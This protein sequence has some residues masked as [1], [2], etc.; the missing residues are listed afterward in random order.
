MCARVVYCNSLMFYELFFFLIVRVH[1]IK[2]DKTSNQKQRKYH[3]KL[4]SNVLTWS[5]PACNVLVGENSEITAAKSTVPDTNKSTSNRSK[6]SIPSTSSASSLVPSVGNSQTTNGNGGIVSATGSTNS[7]GGNQNKFSNRLNRFKRS[8]VNNAHEIL[9]SD[10]GSFINNNKIVK[11]LNNTSNQNSKRNSKIANESRWKRSINSTSE[12]NDSN[13]LV[14][15][16]EGSGFNINVDESNRHNNNFMETILNN[17]NTDHL[18]ANE[19]KHFAN[20]FDVTYA[21]NENARENN[22]N[23][24]NIDNQVL[25]VIEDLNNENFVLIIDSFDNISDSTDMVDVFSQQDDMDDER[26]TS[27]SNRNFFDENSNEKITPSIITTEGTTTTTSTISSH[28]DNEQPQSGEQIQNEQI[29]LGTERSAVTTNGDSE[30]SERR[31]E[32]LRSEDTIDST[33]QNDSPAI[34]SQYE[35]QLPTKFIMYGNDNSIEDDKQPQYSENNIDGYGSIETSTAIKQQEPRY[36]IGEAHNHSIKTNDLRNTQRILVNVSIATDSGDGTRNHGIYMLHVSVPAP[37]LMPQYYASN[38]PQYFIQTPSMLID[39][40]MASSQS[41][42]T[43]IE[44][45]PQTLELSG[46]KSHIEASSTSLFSPHNASIEKSIFP[47]DCNGEILRLN[48][49]IEQLNKT[50][51][52]RKSKFCQNNNSYYENDEN[53]ESSVVTE[54][55]EN[56]LIT[57]DYQTSTTMSS[58]LN[59]S[60]NSNNNDSSENDF[61]R[62]NVGL[63]NQDIPPILI[64]E[65]K[66]F[67]Y[68]PTYT[69]YI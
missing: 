43:L 35:Q 33:L 40:A 39:P 26:I 68:N 65:G 9:Q 3:N 69:S 23:N 38:S 53:D 32:E 24:N 30:N 12:G 64:L 5:N 49:I 54:T 25:P 34:I 61:G 17:E 6:P 47:S 31:L 57:N 2:N 7:V 45:I 22:N 8:L 29:K 41:Q 13:E 63:C 18:N 50:I 20:A 27:S 60:S 67:A 21:D 4:G 11:N 44:P 19:K 62:N 55:H 15:S 36:E 10:I 66:Q 51:E 48:T 42:A 59:A 37:D 16:A 28:F 52:N 58:N 14:D 46:Q 56:E 1:T